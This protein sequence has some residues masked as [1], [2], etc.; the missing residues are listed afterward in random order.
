[1]YDPELEEGSRIA[2]RY[3]LLKYLGSGSYGEVW[4]AHDT[5]LDIDLAIKLYISLDKSAQDDFKQEYR[6]VYGLHEEHLLTP[7]YYGV[8]EHRPYLTM[9]YC[10]NGSAAKV[11]GKVGEE[12]VWQ[13]IHD[14]AA[15]LRY[16]HNLEPPIIHQDIKPENILIDE[17]N[18]FLIT[19]FGISRKMRSTMRKQSKRSLGSGAIAYMGPERFL[20]EPISVK[21]SDIWSLGVS[22]YE[23]VVNDLPFMGQGGGMLLGGAMLPDLP[24][25]WSEDLNDCIRDCM[26]KETWDRPTADQLVEYTVL[27]LSG[28]APSWNKFMGK[29][30]KKKEKAPKKPKAPK[31][32]PDP[33][34]PESGSRKSTGKIVAIIFAVLAVIGIGVGV[35]LSAGP[36][37]STSQPDPD[38]IAQY[39]DDADACAANIKNFDADAISLI[40]TTN[41]KIAD[42]EA[43]RAN[44]SYLT[45]VKDVNVAELRSDYNQAVDPIYSKYL[46]C[47][48]SLISSGSQLET[49]I[50]YLH[51]AGLI[52][53]GDEV[54]S[55]LDKLGRRIGEASIF[56]AVTDVKVSGD[57]MTITYTGMSSNNIT[58]VNIKYTLT[59]DGTTV[60]G[61][62]NFT[63][64][65]GSGNT[66]EVTLPQSVGNPS[67][68]SLV[69][70]GNNFKICS[71][72]IGS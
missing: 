22:A 27:K 64:S 8:W 4:L 34:D 39:R 67:D 53:P 5:E 70:S 65:H 23:L 9:K 10:P 52:K 33:N 6:V 59:A 63:L 72:P 71:Y 15:G 44:N 49:A 69:I 31:P 30:K 68:V 26:A 17:R 48:N 13:F 36:D 2:D 46:N 24:A 55:A 28:K 50:E 40:I 60:K 11:A 56:M 62:E 14:V 45:E 54:F 20:N 29:G 38:I 58:G 3:E 25:G 51:M 41:E 7:D 66:L 37:D 1:M 35:W 61:T 18:C 57:I 43:L 21:A 32:Q 42:L 16:L 19:D 12:V 47:A